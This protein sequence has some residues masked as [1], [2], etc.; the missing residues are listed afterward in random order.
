M[1]AEI[2]NG[3]HAS[4]ETFA[5][6]N[7]FRLA[8]DLL[9][10]NGIDADRIRTVDIAREPFP[11]QTFNLI[12]AFASWGFHYPVET[13]LDVAHDA[14]ESSGVLVLDIRRGQGGEASLARKFGQEPHV[15]HERPKYI[16]CAVIKR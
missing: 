1:S 5:H 4:T 8:I 16:R 10:M 3:Y 2:K 7:S 12:H 6:Y 9:T 13:Y 15:L 14:L 11:E